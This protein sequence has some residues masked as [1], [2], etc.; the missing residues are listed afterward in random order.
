MPSGE[1]A[2]LPGSYQPIIL[3]GA[4]AFSL[5]RRHALAIGNNEN[6]NENENNN[7]EHDDS[8]LSLP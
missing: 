3:M 5:G 7:N 2:L 1:I 8:E 6:E 4:A